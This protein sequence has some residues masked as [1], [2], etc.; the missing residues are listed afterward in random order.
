GETGTRHRIEVAGGH[1]LGGYVGGPPLVR[2]HRNVHG[3]EDLVRRV[4][5]R[6]DE[7]LAILENASPEVADE[8]LLVR[9][10]GGGAPEVLAAPWARRRAH[11]NSPSFCRESITSWDRP[12]MSRA[13]AAECSPMDGA[14]KGCG[15][16]RR[17]VI[18]VRTWPKGPSSGCRSS[19]SAL[20]SWMEGSFSTRSSMSC[21]GAASTPAAWSRSAVSAAS[22]RDVQAAISSPPASDCSIPTSSSVLQLIATQRSSPAAG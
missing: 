10:R 11:T 4:R 7:R 3:V 2:H 16:A 21:T 5:L 20:R 14:R 12:A 18:G 17:K 8:C 6:H 15:R 19:T 22:M 9:G 13:T 1:L